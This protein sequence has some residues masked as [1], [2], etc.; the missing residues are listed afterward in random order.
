MHVEI[1]GGQHT[2]A[3]TWWADMQRQNELWIPGDRVLRFPAWV[4]RARPAEVVGQMRAAL[5]A[6]GW[7]VGG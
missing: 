1:D 7:D 3:H 2:D 5:A 6:G 4:V